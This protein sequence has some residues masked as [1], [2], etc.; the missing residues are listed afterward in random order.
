MS[1]KRG[2]DKE[3]MVHIQYGVLF[4][5]KMEQNWVI[6]SD[7]DGPRVCHT[8]WRKSMRKTNIIL[9]MVYTIYIY[10]KY[11]WTNLQSRNRD[12][13]VENGHVD[14]GKERWDE[15]GR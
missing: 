3:D 2:M 13:E 11:W 5:H 8:E 15:L 12:A 6:C 4:S 14:T 7:V 9:Y 1:I 10:I